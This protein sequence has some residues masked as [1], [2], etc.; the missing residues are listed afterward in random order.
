MNANKVSIWIAWLLVSLFYAYQY[1]LRV[2]P[3][4]VM[5]EV[6]QKFEINAEIF[7]Q[8]AGI[9]YLTYA[10]AHLPIGAWLDH[11]GPKLVI[12][13]CI[14]LA[15]SGVL[16][17]LYSD[18]WIMA[19]IGRALIGFGSSAAIL[20]LF[21][22]V[23]LG[24]EEGKFSRMLGIGVTI[25]LAGGIYGGSPVS[26]MVAKYG[27]K[28]V[29]ESIFI[30]GIILAAVSFFVMPKAKGVRSS[31]VN[32]VQDFSKLWQIKKVFLIAVL[33]GLMI[34]PLEG[35]GDAWGA[36]FLQTVYSMAKS[37]A[38]LLTTLISIGMFIGATLI[39]YI[40]DKTKTYYGIIIFS[41]FVMAGAFI[42]LLVPYKLDFTMLQIMF[43]VIGLLS[44]Y[45]ILAV[46]KST[47]Y[48]KEGLV[49]ITTATVN[50][51]IMPFGYL[52]H[53]AIGKI[54][55]L[56]WDGQIIDGIRVYN[57][58][59]FLYGIAIIPITLIIGGIGF[60]WLRSQ[61]KAQH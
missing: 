48:V 1:V 29:I 9:Y 47:T 42:T 23:H 58:H 60:I 46:Y 6:M 10:G 8:F 40:A 37:E 26:N 21:K 43:F 12:P 27:Y 38:T 32:F 57:A 33:S 35:F 15:A 53:S 19:C 51:I 5:P 45:Q 54:L 28:S 18:S 3:N 39:P 30:I 31:N 44:S 17:L 41:A 59:S 61:P 52:F 7:G 55:N 16:P 11:K 22:V 34:S 4:I 50:M 49:G 14:I 13:I 56:T 20:G 24:F 25:G 2:L 36:A